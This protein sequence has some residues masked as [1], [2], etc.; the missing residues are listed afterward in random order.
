MLIHVTVDYD[1][2]TEYS[3]VFSFALSRQDNI[4]LHSWCIY[5]SHTSHS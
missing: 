2:Y 5:K 1:L 4:E 3:Y